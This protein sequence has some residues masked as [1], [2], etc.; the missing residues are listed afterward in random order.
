MKN[1]KWIDIFSR[2]DSKTQEFII[3][4]NKYLTEKGN[5]ETVR[6]IEKLYGK[7]RNT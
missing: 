4:F 3:K 6:L 2:R 5:I 1:I 7:S